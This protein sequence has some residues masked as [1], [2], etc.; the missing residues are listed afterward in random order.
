SVRIDRAQFD[1]E[2]RQSVSVPLDET[3]DEARLVV[4]SRRD[5]D[6]AILQSA[7]D[8]GATLVPERVRDVSVDRNGMSLRTLSGRY[9]SDRVLGA[10]GVSSLVRRR[11]AS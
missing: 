1:D 11:L 4:A 5:F 8:L 7:L 2:R 9:T 6:A 10:D 3:P